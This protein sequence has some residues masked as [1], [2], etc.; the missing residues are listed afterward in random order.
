M[1]GVEPV[2]DVAVSV[3]HTLRNVIKGQITVAGILTLMYVIGFGLVNILFGFPSAIAIAI[4]AGVCRIV[5]YLDIFVGLV[6]SGIVI[7][8]NFQNWGQVI[9]VVGVIAV[10]QLI[11]GMYITP[12]VVGERVGLHPLIVILSVLAFAD[13]FGFWGVLLAIPTVAVAKIV[14]MSL[15]PLYRSSQVFRTNH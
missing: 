4:V 9:G 11:D 14:F 8:S 7:T 2:K 13:W 5:P 1:L 10:V 12:R 3:D 6:L 15:M